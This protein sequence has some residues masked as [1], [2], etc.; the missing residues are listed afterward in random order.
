MKQQL[1]NVKV[2]YNDVLIHQLLFRKVD[3]LIIELSWPISILKLRRILQN[4]R[5]SVIKEVIKIIKG[6]RR[7]H[8]SRRYFS[9][10][11]Y[12]IGFQFE[13]SLTDILTSLVQQCKQVYN[14]D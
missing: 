14:P 4:C 10:E 2:L 11:L 1:Q 8:L 9:M 3:K 6:K 7:F 13:L 12:N 5:N